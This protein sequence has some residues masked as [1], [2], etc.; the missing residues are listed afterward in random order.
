MTNLSSRKPDRRKDSRRFSPTGELLLRSVSPATTLKDRDEI[1]CLAKAVE[2][3]ESVLTL[4]RKHRVQPLLL[5]ALEVSAPV[6][7]PPGVLRRLRERVR[8]NCERCDRLA[9]VAVTLMTA[10]EREGIRVVAYKGVTLSAELHGDHAVRQAWDLDLL[11]S[12]DDAE[13]AG[14]VLEHHGFQPERWFDQAT[15]YVD[16]DMKLEVDLQHGLTP[17][18]FP[19]AIDLRGILARRRPLKLGTGEVFGPAPEDQLCLLC[20]QLGKD[21][22][23]RRQRVESIAKVADLAEAARRY[24]P[25]EWPRLFDRARDEGWLRLL[26]FGLGLAERLCGVRIEVPSARSGRDESAALQLVDQVCQ[27][28]FDEA[29]HVACRAGG[30]AR[31]PQQR[32]R[33]LRFYLSL[34]ERPADRLRHLVQIA[35]RGWP[36]LWRGLTQRRLSRR[37]TAAADRDAAATSENPALG[38]S[39]ARETSAGPRST[40]ARLWG[41]WEQG[42]ELA[43][44]SVRAVWNVSPRLTSGLIAAS[45]VG[46]LTPLMLFLSIRGVINARNLAG[47]GVEQG[48]S[49]VSFWM[50]VLLLAAVFESLASLVIRL[51]R[52]LLLDRCNRDITSEIMTRSAGLPI[53]FFE[54][55]RSLDLVER[56]QSNVS[57]RLVDFISRIAAI[58]TQGIQIATISA[59]MVRLEPLVIA[60]VAP[61]F[62]P[63]LWYQLR[64]NRGTFESQ[65]H[66][67]ESRRRIAYYLRLVTSIGNAAEV[68]L[69]GLAPHLVGQFRHLMDQAMQRDARGHWRSFWG[70]AGFS[71]LSLVVF[72]GLMLRMSLG[73][74]GRSP[75]PG[76]LAFFAAAAIRL[77]KSLEDV[78]HTLKA[79]VDHLGYI[80]ALRGF[81]AEPIPTGLT[82]AAPLPEPFE[83]EIVCTG[84]SFH[85]PGTTR[86]VLRNLNL[87]I[88]PGETV[89]IVGENGSGK[90]TLVKLLAGFYQPTAGT[91]RVSGQDL[92]QLDVAQVQRRIAFVF[93]D[94]GRYCA[95]V[96]ENIAYGDWPALSADDARIG[97]FATLA[98]L[99]PD[100]ARMPRG[101]D[102]V[103]GR[104]FGEY[105]PSGGVWQ[106]IA[107]ARAFA[108]EAPILILDEPTASIDAR[109]EFELFGRLVELSAGRT[110]IL[111]SHRFSTVALASRILV[112]ERGTI[113]EQGTHQELLASGGRYATLYGYSQ[114]KL[115]DA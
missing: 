105:E 85:Y 31:T 79:C 18:F 56:L 63:Y 84:L 40:A 42:W 64:L 7:P 28:L 83:P 73:G 32:W 109:A 82:L 50:L 21:C 29:D 5:R 9:A 19:V 43:K 60:A 68:R 54:E 57:G 23:E 39:Q 92:A 26:H 74:G 30:A 8:A 51:V 113:V 96:S 106:R 49:T 61:C 12:P 94:Y 22:W 103:L 20:L 66:A 112:L 104:Q 25:S 36:L 95:S 38:A 102:T 1:R 67:A 65:P 69:L 76:D 97:H 93:Q 75:S 90:S 3:W 17:R 6:V 91:V 101:F 44:W 27:D 115:P 15:D 24:P 114:R 87:R 33:Q 100:L 14:R 55:R 58:G 35:W 107:L 13:R 2:D 59:A 4:A 80:G 46:G 62:L 99:N 37:G 81:L 47:R 34:R 89:A 16:P 78:S 72:V 45:L 110:T 88:E 86:E 48:S 111:I 71:T 108:R 53:R 98:G 10:L 77:R 70:G 52:S 11:I 41:P